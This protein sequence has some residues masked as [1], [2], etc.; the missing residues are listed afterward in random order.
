MK[1]CIV[2]IP[3]YKDVITREERASIRQTYRILGHHD[4][5]FVTHARC[6]LETYQ[7][8]VEAEHGTLRAEFFDKGYFDST[9]HYSN[10]CFSEEFYLR[11][12]EYE[13]MLICQTDAWVFRDELDYWCGL[14]YDYIG[15]P[16]YFPY[17]KKRF[18]N[19][20]FGVGNGGFCLR[21]IS[22]CLRIVRH[23]KNK[24]LL[25]PQALAR[26]Y[27]YYFLYN[28]AFTSNIFRR[29]GLAGKLVA[30]CL[31][32]GN[33]AG[34]FIRNHINEDMLFGTWATQSWGL[35]SCSIPDELTAARFAMELNAPLLYKRLNGQ[36]PF[37]CHAFEK[38]DYKEFWYTHIQL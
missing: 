22:H 30:K 5:V 33:T 3:I 38:W 19:I 16:I 18:T 9:E 28:E 37:G 36:L 20:F 34:Y 12:K 27:W 8:I 31:G 7:E 29:I 17:N 25:K 15:A 10:L 11:F 23:D 1:S 4:I 35:E 26:M 21:K 14:G 24:V 2:V 32:L 13:Y 6:R